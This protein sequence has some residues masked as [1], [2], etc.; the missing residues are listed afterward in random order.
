MQTPPLFFGIPRGRQR[1]GKTGDFNRL[2]DPSN[3]AK[4]ACAQPA[5]VVVMPAMDKHRH[6]T[7]AHEHPLTGAVPE[8]AL[9]AAAMTMHDEHLLVECP[10]DSQEWT[11]TRECVAAI[12]LALAYT[13]LL[14]R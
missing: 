8:D 5:S 4:K 6:H 2:L 3:A 7:D 11:P 10:V 12:A 9:N 14:V 13:M 1:G